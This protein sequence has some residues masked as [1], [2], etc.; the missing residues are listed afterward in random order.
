MTIQ[1]QVFKARNSRLK[2]S[3][4]VLNLIDA[5]RR[6]N[7]IGKDKKRAYLSLLYDAISI[8]DIRE[9]DVYNAQTYDV[10]VSFRA[11]MVDLQRTKERMRRLG[12]NIFPGGNPKLKDRAFAQALN[13]PVPKTFYV[14]ARFEDIKLIPNSIL[15][16]VS[17][18]ASKGVF[19]VDRLRKLH[20]L[21]SGRTYESLEGARAEIERFRDSISSNRWV[22]EEAI[23]KPS[24]DPAN[25]FKVFAF[26]GVAGM[27]LEI[28]RF[29]YPE[30]R[31]ATYTASGR[32]IERG[33]TYKSF[34]GSGVPEDLRTYTQKLSLAAPVPFLRLDF[35]HGENCLYLGEITPHPGGT[36]AGDHFDVIDKMLGEH[37]A[38][39]KARIYLD[40]LDGKTFPEFHNV[41]EAQ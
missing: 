8:E 26:Y 40:L 18:A 34:P 23:L 25:D 41:Y 9:V 2:A 32:Q 30:P 29:S 35:H 3:Q 39:A 13:V 27:F 1:E 17:G 37:L 4:P 21:K 24:G 33:G 28:D 16:P 15:K 22:S 20:S 10:G 12:R 38:E 5:I 14:N 7:T 11:G 6:D 31:Y 19:H 36:Y